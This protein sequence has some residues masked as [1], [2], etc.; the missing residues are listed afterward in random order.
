MKL[1][2]L[3]P[4]AERDVHFYLATAEKL[5]ANTDLKILFL[6]FF[7]PGNELIR[8]KGYEVLDPYQNHHFDPV[9]SRTVSQIE[10]DFQTPPLKD[11]LLHEKL[12]FGI[13][14]DQPVLEKFRRFFSSIDQLLA[15]VEKRFPSDEK[16]ILQE[17]AGFVGPLSLFYV[18]IKRGWTNWMTE[19]S[20]FKGR[21]HFLKDDLYLHIPNCSPSSETQTQVSQY[22]K[23]AMEQKVVVAATKDAHHYKDM[24]VGK[25][26]NVMNLQKLSK[27]L[28]FKYIKGE[29]QE[30][31]HIWNHVR[32][33]LVMLKNRTENSKVYASLESLAS[34]KK[35]F[36]F[37]FHVQL[38]FA[39]T[40]R[41]PQWLD[42]LGLIENILPHL[43]AEAIL[44]AKEHPAS[45]GCLD[46]TRLQKVL[47]NPQFRLLHPQINSHDIMERTSGV[48]TINSKVGAEAMCKGLPVLSFG[49]AFYTEKDY[50]HHFSNWN[51]IRPLFENWASRKKD[52]QTVNPEWIQFLN[53]VWQTSSPTELY[54]LTPT[55]IEDFTN[56]VKKT[57]KI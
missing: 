54:D 5:R 33:Y 40:I 56:S 38:D 22:L 42:Q 44:V 32:R 24:G 45:I 48:V 37:P 49:K 17:L 21:I 10:N 15:Q 29:K 51:E 8:Q 34:E 25:V 9:S 53:C 14:D 28:Y 7:Q 20:F 41:C 13:T 6:S 3:T 23:K 55:N 52:S 50:T 19:P 1:L 31:D 35:I 30:F 12:T 18:G 2:I 36:Y 4:I 47:K 27:K 39:L 43:P 26:F 46:Q 11:L 57:L 16:F